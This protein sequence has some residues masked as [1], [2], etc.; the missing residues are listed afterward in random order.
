MSKS[1]KSASLIIINYKEFVLVMKTQNK[2]IAIEYFN[3]VA[4]G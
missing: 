4:H 2:I 3:N 1:D